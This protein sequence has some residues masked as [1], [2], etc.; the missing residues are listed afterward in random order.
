MNSDPY[1]SECGSA[2]LALI[3]IYNDQP[4]RP[5]TIPP[6]LNSLKDFP[7]VAINNIL[8]QYVHLDDFSVIFSKSWKTFFFSNS[9]NYFFI[10]K[11]K[12]KNCAGKSYSEL[13]QMGRLWWDFGPNDKLIRG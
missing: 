8:V 13:V 2:T 4:G 7:Q 11:H 5:S 3:N 1:R 12:K 10:C 9:L 6:H